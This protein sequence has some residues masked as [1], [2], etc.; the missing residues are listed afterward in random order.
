MS[1]TQI[2]KCKAS[3]I[4]GKLT[5]GYNPITVSILSIP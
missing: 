3:S 4:I 2:Q 1:Y 5:Q